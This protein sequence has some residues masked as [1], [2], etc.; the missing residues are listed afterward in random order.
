[1][2]RPK[3]SKNKQP[4]NSIDERIET[5]SA[6]IDRLQAALKEK[7]D[8]IKALKSEQREEMHKKIIKAAD[9]SGKSLE[10]ILALIRS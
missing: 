8:E 9:E 10:E 6:E 3:G 4:V 5:V 2:A 7:K 1:M